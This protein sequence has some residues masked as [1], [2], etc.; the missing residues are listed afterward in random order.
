MHI[1]YK[2]KSTANQSTTWECKRRTNF[3]AAIKTKKAQ[4][5]NKTHKNGS[6]IKK[7]LNQHL[8]AQNEQQNFQKS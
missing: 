7:Q 6:L 4:L 1:F 2:I 8:C 3:I 5:C